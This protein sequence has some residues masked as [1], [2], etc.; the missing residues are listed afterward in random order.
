MGPA[1]V[2]GYLRLQ[3]A[4]TSEIADRLK[5]ELHEYAKR[6]ALALVEIYIDHYPS[7]NQQGLETAA[8]CAL[9]DALRR[10]TSYGVVIPSPEHLSESRQDREQRCRIIE[11]EGGVKLLVVRSSEWHDV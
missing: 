3:P 9:M 5:A 11:V 2:F 4:D 10:V 8:F 1:L 7:V 6:H